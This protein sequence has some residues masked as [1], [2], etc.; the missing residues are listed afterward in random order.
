MLHLKSVGENPSLSRPSFWWFANN[1]WCSL[2]CI[3]I[4]DSIVTWHSLCLLS[5]YE[6]ILLLEYDFILTY[7]LITSAKTLFP[8]KEI[9]YIHRYQGS[10][11][12]ISFLRTQQTLILEA[13]H[14]SQITPT[15]P[16]PHIHNT[17]TCLPLLS[18]ISHFLF[19]YSQWKSALRAM[20]QKGNFQQLGV[21]KVCFY[22]PEGSKKRI[23]L[24][25][26]PGFKK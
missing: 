5:C 19:P 14:S 12:N 24:F 26:L 17:P 10:E 23:F 2:A 3:S 7:I 4:S 11:F 1:T 18:K 22:C 15:L 25:Q 9:T 20:G 8:N 13:H 16:S 6:D 21:R